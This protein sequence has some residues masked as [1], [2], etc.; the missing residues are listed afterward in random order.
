VR[1][2]IP[3]VI[4]LILAVVG[5]VWWT[6]TWNRDFVSVPSPAKL[7]EI[8][9][10]IESSLP[11]ADQVDDAISPTAVVEAPP[12][13]ATEPPKPVIDPADLT[14]PP[15]LWSYRNRSSR[16]PEYLTELAMQLETQGA[17][18]RA[19]LAWE[20][21][22]DSTN[23]SE[24]QS[25]AAY[26]AIRRLRPTQPQWNT[27]PKSCIPITLHVRTGK[28]LVKSLNPILTEV[29]RDLEQAASGIIKFKP[30]ISTAPTPPSY[31][32]PPRVTLW[33]SGPDKKSPS[34]ALL[35]FTIETPEALRPV[36]LKNIFLLTYQCLIPRA[37]TVTTS[38][39]VGE[40]KLKDILNFRVTRRRW[41]EFASAMNPPPIQAN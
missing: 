38:R 22:I 19:L 7:Q 37:A 20:R 34:T 4:L 12:P 8:R 15:T 21:V 40:D 32:G 28:K 35:T 26:A 30:E 17:A 41:S 25:A 13:Q 29:I 14:T 11:Q 24:S 27:Q 16:G 33:L 36:V 5:G 1:V 6:Q 9:V 39:S 18:N 23:P 31:Q 10:K 2:P 3:V